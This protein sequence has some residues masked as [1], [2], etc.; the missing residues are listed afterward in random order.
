MSFLPEDYPQ[1]RHAI[2][3]DN[4]VLF[5]GAGLSLNLVNKQGEKIGDWNNL[6]R[7]ILD[8]LQHGGM[9]AGALLQL[10]GH[11]EPIEVLHL[12]ERSRHFSRREVDSFLKDFLA[13]GE[14]DWTLHEKL[15]RLS[16][17]IITTN[18]DT[19]FETCS[20]VLNDRVAHEG[21][22]YE[23]A[24][25]MD[26]TRP[27]LFKLHGCI[28]SSSSMVLFPSGYGRLY[29]NEKDRS[30]RHALFTLRN[31]VA[32]RSILFIGCGMGDF[33]IN[34]LF[35]EIKNIQGDYSRPH[36]IIS[37][38]KPDSALHFLT[39]IQ[40]GDH[41]E[42]P[43][44]VDALLSLKQQLA[45]EARKELS[46]ME[47]QV[48]ALKS[49]LEEKRSRHTILIPE[50][51]EEA[52]GH[53][54]AGEWEKAIRKYNQIS[55][56]DPRS[57]TV[58][59]NW[60]S[61]LISLAR[62]APEAGKRQLLEDSLT[63]FTQAVS[64][65]DNDARFYYNW[66][67]GLF[68]LAEISADGKRKECL[69]Q[70]IAKYETAIE[71]KADYAKA[72]HNLG[73][74]LAKLA[75]A[76]EDYKERAGLY[77]RALSAYEKAAELNPNNANIWY[78]LG[79]ALYDLSQIS[80]EPE[81]TALV[82]KTCDAYREALKHD[83]SHIHAL[84]DLGMVLFLRMKKVTA[85]ERTALTA[86]AEAILL[87]TAARNRPTYNLA[88]LYVLLQ[89]KEKALFYLDLALAGNWVAADYVLGDPDWTPY[90]A[91]PD[92]LAVVKRYDRSS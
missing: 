35:A 37:K 47:R 4:L 67:T 87:E 22:D 71:K 43:Q 91:D 49:E 7:K 29:N 45:D 46:E 24:M 77:A 81:Q 80:P 16:S 69:E 15:T 85:E 10:I 5:I 40:I 26:R 56:L 92:W 11:Y 64:L 50:L 75:E 59:S 14:N 73:I 86:E 23:L 3:Q 33:Q 36:F 70:S 25:H 60:G 9:P 42:I 82:Q 66:A 68:A 52:L 17:L 84:E 34:H 21:K 90:L 31:L 20:D 89:Q 83:G 62:T 2:E 57:A 41:H 88:C 58:Y 32:N 8:H 61:A 38:T 39:H 79:N 30:V 6:V 19:A 44:V 72:R 53:G 1:L 65:K 55:T 13:L 76:H 18:Y 54:N 28:R 63:K 78:N 48:E 12:I 27:L 74:A 51:F